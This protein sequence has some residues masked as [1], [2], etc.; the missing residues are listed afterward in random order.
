M[1]A[2][3]HRMNRLGAARSIDGRPSALSN[4]AH[5]GAI[6]ERL[7]GTVLARCVG[8]GAAPT[9]RGLWAHGRSSAHRLQ[10]RTSHA[11]KPTCCT[12]QRGK[13]GKRSRRFS[14][15]SRRAPNVQVKLLQVTMGHASIVVTAH[16]YAYLYDSDL[17]RVLDALDGLGG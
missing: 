17:D 13:R 14:A 16:T 15:N 8:N 2:M 3:I 11:L 1:S 4:L 12:Q 10:R 7:V 6:V 9:G 5:V